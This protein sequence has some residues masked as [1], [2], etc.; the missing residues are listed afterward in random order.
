MTNNRKSKVFI[1]RNN[2]ILHI[3]GLITAFGGGHFLKSFAD[4]GKK[5]FLIIGLI[6]LLIAAL[7]I[8]FPTDVRTIENM[9]NNKE[10]KYKLFISAIAF[11]IFMSSLFLAILLKSIYLVIISVISFIVLVIIE[12]KI[13]NNN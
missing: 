8:A 4:T 9:E 11:Y 10:I 13:K 12:V 7:T 3:V 2:T 6:L 5:S 1:I